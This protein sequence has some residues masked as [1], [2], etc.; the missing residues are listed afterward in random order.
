MNVTIRQMRAFV[1]VADC[2]SFT[3]AAAEMHI[4]QSGLS[5][6]IRGLENAIGARLID[7]TS[8]SMA[9]TTVGREFRAS[10]D[11][12]LGEIDQ[13]LKS[14]NE[15]VTKR[16][17]RLVIAAPLV[18]AST[19]LPPVLAK[20]RTSYPEVDLVLKDAL[21]DEVLPMVRAAA[22]D[23]GIGT[24]RSS[25]DVRYRLL[26]RES[27]VAVVPKRD[28]LASR[29]R[30]TWRELK[31]RQVLLLPRGSVFRE[32]AERG[33]SRAGIEIEPAFEA[34]YVGTLLGLVRAGLGVAI[35]PGYATA[36]LERG[37]TNWCRLE[38]PVVDREVSMA[39]RSGASLSPAA[40]AF[41]ELLIEAS[42]GTATERAAATRGRSAGVG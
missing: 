42:R 35:V 34:T 31:E 26:F 18:L 25:D 38:R 27:L 30:V 6:L 22:A 20:F 36:L 23:L 16:R 37:A 41:S 3:R 14:V 29:T 24:F 39:Y 7:R 1:L 2:G 4:T 32:L 15:L 8:R 28:P 17:G 40:Q 9:L 10:A 5:L 19:F 33:F 21:P 12:V 11:R 13:S